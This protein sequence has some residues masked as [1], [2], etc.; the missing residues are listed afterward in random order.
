MLAGLSDRLG[1]EANLARERGR[2]L[3]VLDGHRR[4]LR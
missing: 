4:R 2:E 3:P 1:W